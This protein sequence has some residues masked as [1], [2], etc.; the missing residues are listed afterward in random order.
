MERALCNA[1]A[2]K[3]LYLPGFSHYLRGRRAKSDAEKVMKKAM[4]HDGLTQLVARFLPVETF[5]EEG[6]RRRLFTPMVAFVAFL[7]QVMNRGSSCREAVRRVQAWFIE[8]GKEAPD[9]ST[10]AYC[11][12]RKRLTI[13]LLRKAHEKICDWFEG[14][15]EAKDLW[16]GHVVK[17]IDGTG[18]SMPDSAANRAVYPYA[19]GQQESIGFPTGKLVGL[20]S[21]ATGHLVKF[22]QGGWKHHDRLPTNGARMEQHSQG[23]QMPPSR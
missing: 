6:M 13:G 12:A 1:M 3:T 18:F 17:V 8:A 20:F 7:G 16:R 9:D 15:V 10:S 4:T 14:Q 19:G 22:M 21:L 5:H 23:L 11:Q 2:I